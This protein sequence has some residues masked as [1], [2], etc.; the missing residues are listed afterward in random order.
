[1]ETRERKYMRNARKRNRGR[2]RRKEEGK[3]KDKRRGMP[4][5]EH[6]LGY[7]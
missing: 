6:F 1:M 2:E 7:R 5:G 4:V 3:R